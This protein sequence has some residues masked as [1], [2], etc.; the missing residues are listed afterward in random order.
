MKMLKSLNDSS[1]SIINENIKKK[2]GQI[3]ISDKKKILILN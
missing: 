3:F 2:Q 1:L